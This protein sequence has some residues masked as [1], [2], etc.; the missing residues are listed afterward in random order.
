M[1]LPHLKKDNSPG[2]RIRGRS[3]RFESLE[4][5]ALLTAV[6]S[7]SDLKYY[8][9]LGESDIELTAD[10]TV[11]ASD[12][13]TIGGNV[14][15][16][17]GT[18][19]HTITA[20]GET[21][22]TVSL[23]TV[24]NDRSLTVS[25]LT[26]SGLVYNPGSKN[27]KGAVFYQTGGTITID[28]STT[29]SNCSAYYGAVAYLTG[30]E[31]VVGSDNGFDTAVKISG[32]TVTGDGGC[33]Y[34]DGSGSTVTVKSGT[35]GGDLAADGNRADSAGGV[36]YLTG[37]SAVNVS[38]GVFKSNTA[39]KGGVFRVYNNARLT[40]TGGTISANTT[41]GQPGGAV[42]YATGGTITIGADGSASAGPSI[43]GNTA[44]SSDPSSNTAINGG[45]VISSDSAGTVIYI[46]S[47]TISGN[48]VGGAN[49]KGGGVAF[50][51]QGKLYI[52]G[53]TIEGN[54]AA[55][56]DGGVVYIDDTSSTETTLSISG[57]S[58][59]DN[60]AR[61]GSVVYCSNSN[62]TVVI[63]GGDISNNE[64][65]GTTGGGVVFVN[66]GA[67]T[68]SG[69]TISGNTGEYGGAVY[70][71]G[72]I[73]ITGGT[74]SENSA[75]GR[76][77]G[78][79]VY[80]VNSAAV[81][82]EN[83]AVFSNNTAPAGGV[84]FLNQ[85][86]LT[87]S[88]G[89]FTGNSVTGNGGVIHTDDS[90][91]VIISGGTFSGNSAG[92][93]GGVVYSGGVVNSQGTVVSGSSISVSSGIF[94]DNTARRGG[95]FYAYAGATV[96]VSGGTFGGT[97]E[98][99]GIDGNSA[100]ADGGVFFVH[101][102]TVHITGGTFAGNTAANY[103]GICC[104][105]NRIENESGSRDGSAAL[106]VDGVSFAR[107]SAR[108]GGAIY[109][110][111]IPPATGTS[112]TSTV[113]SLGAVTM[114]Y[115]S[116]A[117][118]GAIANR[119]AV[120]TDT[121]TG[122]STA[123]VKTFTGNSGKYNAG[124]EEEPVFVGNGGAI[125]NTGTMT[126]SN[127]VFSGNYSVGNGGAVD[128]LA[129]G[130]L[131]LTGA[132][133]SGN[134]ALAS[135]VSLSDVDWANLADSA[136]DGG[137]L[138]NWGTVTLID[139]YFTGNSAHDGGAIANGAGAVLTLSQTTASDSETPLGFVGN[140]AVYGGAIIN[141]GTLTRLTQT[142][143]EEPTQGVPQTQK[144]IFARNTSYANGGA[145]ANSDNGGA[146]TTGAIDLYGLSFTDNTA[147]GAEGNNT[148]SGGAI[149]SAK[150]LTVADSTFTGNSASLGGKG[151]AI[152]HT[153]GTLILTGD[154]FTGNS[155]S[156]TGFGG[157]VNTWA[158]GTITDC[159]F[160]ENSAKYGGAVSVLGND[161]ATTIADTS[162]SGNSAASY[163]GAVYASGTVVID[164]AAISNNTA[165]LG[166]GVMAITS[167]ISDTSVPMMGRGKVI[168]TGEE[169]TF[170]G[171]TAVKKVGG[172]SVGSDLCASSSNSAAGNGAV[173]EI[174][175]MPELN[176]GGYA[177]AV[178]RSILV[179]AG[180]ATL[181]A[182]VSVY[183]NKEF[184]CG[185]T[186]SGN[187]LAFTSL[188][189]RS[190]IDKWWIYW[191]G[192][193]SGPYTEYTAGGTDLPSGTV[194]GGTAV[195]I[196]GYKGTAETLYYMVPT[197]SASTSG[198]AEA[199]FDDTLFDTQVFEWLSQEDT[200]PEEYCDDLFL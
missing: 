43:S 62:T 22:R 156:A 59:S 177:L 9:E 35:F 114:E 63:S 56:K 91:P 39:N 183:S 7:F 104:V 130:T 52:Q 2:A 44:T 119:G 10:I 132:V 112:S 1:S 154:T 89:E 162:L 194:T 53:G 12:K 47:G 61:R 139:A 115:N 36:I 64:A 174:E 30:G 50:I 120:V 187:T 195:L 57:G 148:G 199:L 77:G 65:T 54:S 136:G 49:T 98:A 153:A 92:S 68:I 152:D 140:G 40:V 142:T 189:S 121:G 160:S 107:N 87:V 175:T 74:F 122:G 128:N 4:Q 176:S 76:G 169:T 171:N 193:A 33:F 80:V 125:F 26:I 117:N 170:S 15:I 20:A 124:T 173:I 93:G 37:G 99:P 5:R 102:A 60:V 86:S 190:G 88:G 3:L 106:S 149:V 58:I 8:A 101:G 135:A 90:R 181:P 78:G 198:A 144:I 16:H 146:V 163:G 123:A 197:S 151:G 196:K 51:K 23:F 186:Y 103:G 129:A 32:N 66:K 13:I 31:L 97:G 184:T 25:N 113:V 141:V 105:T 134:S 11:G 165:S 147:G 167:N 145:I 82:I 138:Q 143:E 45:G 172:Q 188:S 133:F 192:S 71:R 46:K 67:L 70:T 168:F 85:G 18:N 42:V 38:G 73:A 108:F 126:L 94:K 79:V 157:A 24:G 179:L 111:Y 17:G 95:V 164:G 34:A 6:S 137:A 200:A 27:S 158:G 41:T 29:I 75:Y 118:G 83:G 81:T 159:D 150:D 69:G 19:G 109:A 48:T 14:S 28:S 127:T 84:V 166:G 96:S 182:T 100:Q 110:A 131:T 155:A 55:G 191:D 72:N 180:G 185:Y 161:T 178:D 116:A 21:T